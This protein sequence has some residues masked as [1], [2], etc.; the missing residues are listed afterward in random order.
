[1][2]LNLCVYM[3]TK[4]VIALMR[5]FITNFTSEWICLNPYRYKEFLAVVYNNHSPTEDFFAVLFFINF[6]IILCNVFCEVRVCCAEERYEM[7]N[8]L[9]NSHSKV[10]Q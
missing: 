4:Q 9:K 10:F 7:S 1:M 5:T 2:N 3:N 8:I 6:I